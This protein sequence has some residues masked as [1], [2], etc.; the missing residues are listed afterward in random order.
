MRPQITS[1]I[2]KNNGRKQPEPFVKDKLRKSIIA[3][4][5]SARAPERRAECTADLVCKDVEKWLQT[6][7]EITSRDI[8]IVTAR[9]L[10][11]Y[12]PE[13]AYLY[14]QRHVTI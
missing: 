11:K 13:A 4:C 8:R 3:T 5:L 7:P 2:I 1:Y 10:K 6:K 12:D 14:E 9:H